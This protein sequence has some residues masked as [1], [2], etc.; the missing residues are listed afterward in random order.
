MTIRVPFVEPGTRPELAEIEAS[1]LAQ[2]GRISDV[3]G[4]NCCP[5]IEG[6]MWQKD[7]PTSTPI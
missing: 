4:A 2:R 7:I 1:I 3:R 6:S 5:S